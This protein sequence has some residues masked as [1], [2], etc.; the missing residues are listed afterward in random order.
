M[1]IESYI[2]LTTTE[3][4]KLQSQVLD[5]LN[6]GYELQGGVSITFNNGYTIYAQAV[7]LR[8]MS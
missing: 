2:I 1:D 5:Y 7:I 4:H 3:S 8:R 6:R